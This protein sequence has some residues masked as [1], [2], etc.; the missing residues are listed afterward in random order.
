[1]QPKSINLWLT[2]SQTC[3]AIEYMLG[4]SGV[5][6]FTAILIVSSNFMEPN[7]YY[8]W[9]FQKIKLDKFASITLFLKVHS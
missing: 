9:N 6:R 7:G 1:M 3:E 2:W 4:Q 8:G 5:E